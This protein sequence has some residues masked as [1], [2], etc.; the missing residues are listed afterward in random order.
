MKAM[1]NVMRSGKRNEKFYK[2]TSRKVITARDTKTHAHDRV[3]R[4]GMSSTILIRFQHE[5]W[6]A[7]KPWYQSTWIQEKEGKRKVKRE[8]KTRQMTREQHNSIHIAKCT[9]G[10]SNNG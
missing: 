5:I 4:L 10:S 8:D 9:N 2:H 6:R 1:H 7:S 3:S